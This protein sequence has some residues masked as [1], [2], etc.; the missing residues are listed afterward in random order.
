[1]VKAPV[2]GVVDPTDPFR[3]PENPPAVNVPE[4]VGDA[5]ILGTPPALVFSM[6]LA[7]VGRPDT[8]SPVPAYHVIWF[9][10]PAFTDPEEVEHGVA[11]LTAFPKASP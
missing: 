2:D 11:V 10:V 6:P 4:I 8:A 9:I 7:R 5:V 1:M 3:G